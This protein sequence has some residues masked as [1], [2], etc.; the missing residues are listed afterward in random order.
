MTP[1]DGGSW[2]STDLPA[3]LTD[4]CLPRMGGPIEVMVLPLLLTRSGPAGTLSVRRSVLNEGRFRH[5]VTLDEDRGTPGQI[6]AIQAKL[7]LVRSLRPT[8]GD[9]EQ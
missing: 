8:H 4:V 7:F 6:T 3:A 1:A 2:H 9:V 5:P